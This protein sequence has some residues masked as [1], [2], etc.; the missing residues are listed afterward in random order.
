MRIVS[1]VLQ[2]LQL[3]SVVVRAG[4]ELLFLGFVAILI[5]CCVWLCIFGIVVFVVFCECFDL[6]L[7]FLVCGVVFLFCLG[8][9]VVLGCCSLCGWVVRCAC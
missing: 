7:V 6:C 5:R 8:F 9:V 3:L 4:Q 1:C 2:I